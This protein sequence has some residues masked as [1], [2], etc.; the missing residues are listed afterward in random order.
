MDRY[1]VTVLLDIVGLNGTEIEPTG[2]GGELLIVSTDGMFSIIQ[3]DDDRAAA[4]RDL[5]DG[6]PD[7][8]TGY[9]VH[10]KFEVTR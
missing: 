2:R 7:M 8:V 3:D 5:L 1:D 9:G 10:W 6:R 4:M